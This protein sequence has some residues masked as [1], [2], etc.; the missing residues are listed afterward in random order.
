MNIYMYSYDFKERIQNS[1]Y[2]SMCLNY[3]LLSFSIYISIFSK[4][5]L[6]NMSR[7]SSTIEILRL[8]IKNIQ[9][10][11]LRAKKFIFVK[12]L[13]GQIALKMHQE[14]ELQRSS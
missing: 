14:S 13:F 5:G 12:I 9:H 10:E 8:D 6:H 4:N 1:L 7:G 2:S 11:L 3:I